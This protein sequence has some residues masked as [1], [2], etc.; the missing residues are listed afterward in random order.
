MSISILLPFYNASPW[1]SET[2]QSIQR[3][4]FE[5][6]ELIA[7]NDFSTDNSNSIL[8]ELAKEDSRIRIYQ[9]NEKGII[10]A[11]QLGLSKAKGE[12]LTRMDADDIMPDD[13]LQVMVERLKSLPTK[14]V[15][16]GKVKHFSNKPVSEG[17]LNY[18]AWLNER[19]EKE[20]YFDH[21]YRECVVASPNW[22]T[23]TD[24][25][26]NFNIFA[27]LNYPE[28]YDMTFHWMNNGF[29]IHG[30][31]ETTLLWR[32]HPHRTSKN[33][34]AYNQKA[35]FQL[36]LKWFCKLNG[37]S[38]IAILGA[39]TKGKLT[40]EFLTDRKIDFNW[41]DLDW[42]KY[43]SPIFGK[44]IQNF[45]SLQAE[46]LLVAIYPKN[47]KPLLDFLTEKGFEIGRNTWFL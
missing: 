20:D 6:W 36:K 5:D 33:S 8:Q 10:H 7:I 21:M 17:Y 25:I 35:L 44:R 38:S 46:K 12:F 11:L 16:T 45:E 30:V 1:I 18:D 15:V 14:S 32:E 43:G 2:I 37:T 28:D 19:V 29:T 41:Y 40:A 4:T 23:R 27:K 9:N 24:E 34:D 26:K 47:K 22:L 42:K 39:G 31:N 13:R 3:Q